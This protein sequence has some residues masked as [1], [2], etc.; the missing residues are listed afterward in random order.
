[1]LLVG[2]ADMLRARFTS[3][4]IADETAYAA[5]P[6][7]QALPR[8]TAAET[9]ERSVRLQA[10]LSGAAE[11]PLEAAG[12]AASLLALCARAA[13]LGNI[14]LVSDVEWR[15]PWSAALEASAANVRINHRFIKD[16]RVV[17]EQAGRSQ[18]SSTPAAAAKLRP[19]EIISAG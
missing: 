5:V 6:A 13:S 18:R 7:A 1:M 4:R 10:A 11:A 16:A 2:E 17:S 3:A 15:S 8:A 9:A 14:H 19:A 12:L